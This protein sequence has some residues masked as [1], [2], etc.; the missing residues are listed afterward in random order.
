MS[1]D[2]VLGIVIL[3]LAAPAL[4]GLGFSALGAALHTVFDPGNP[5]NVERAANVTAAAVANEVTPWWAEPLTWIIGIPG[6]G[7]L[8]GVGFLIWINRAGRWDG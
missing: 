2:K 8:L 6:V 3:V 5:Q 7:G 4:I 1:A